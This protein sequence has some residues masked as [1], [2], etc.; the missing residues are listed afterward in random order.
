MAGFTK[1]IAV[2]ALVAAAACAEGS[3]TLSPAL[4][5]FYFPVGLTVRTLNDG[6]TALVVVSSNFD[7]RYDLAGGGTVIALDPDAAQDSRPTCALP[8]NCGTGIA[9][10]GSAVIGSF[11]GEVAYA[12]EKNCP[13]LAQPLSSPPTPP[14]IAP[15]SGAAKVLVSS[16]SGLTLYRI[17]MAG[18]GSLACGPDCPLVLDGGAFDPYGSTVVCLQSGDQKASVFV[19]QER[20]TQ[21]LSRITEVDLRNGNSRVL[22]D[23]TSLATGVLTSPSFTSAFQKIGPYQRV[24]ATTRFGVVQKTQMYWLDLGGSVSAN[25]A[26]TDLVDARHIVDIYPVVPGSLT[27]D[28][29]ISNDN[30]RAYVMLEL[31]DANLAL[32][33]G[34]FAVLSSALAVFDIRPTFTGDPAMVLLGLV[35]LGTGAGQVRVLPPRTDTLGMPMGDLVA[36]TTG[37]DGALA[38]YDDDLQAVVQ[39]LGADQL[40]GLPVLG[41]QPFGLAVEGRTAGRCLSTTSACDRIYVGSFQDGWVSVVELDPRVPGGAAIVKRIGPQQIG[42]PQP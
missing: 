27:Q 10:L 18:D 19:T 42:A 36:V 13:Q 20:S 37:D 39:I 34:Q 1:K 38:I 6:R 3:P 40:T 32:R 14:A 16:R 35:P 21:D 11:G 25:G 8:A 9:S 30:T 22:H 24:F 23:F 15:G 41:R 28:M 26:I 7:L 4:D 17:D 33:S 31:Y 2:L 29:A 5:S 12:D